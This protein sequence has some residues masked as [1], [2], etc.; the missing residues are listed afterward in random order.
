MRDTL[1]DEILSGRLPA[2][3]RLDEN[4]L[5]ARFG[6]SRTPIREALLQLAASG[7]VD[8][9]PRRSAVVIR[10]GPRRLVEMFE[11]MAELEA[12]CAR[13]AA[14]RA[15]DDDLNAIRGA[16]DACAAAAETSDCDVYYYENE[17]FHEAVV[18]AARNAFLAEQTQ[19]LRKRLKP[20]RRLQLRVPGRIEES[21]GE[22]Q[23][24]A[25]A[26]AAHDVEGAAQGMR[27]HIVVQGERFSD[28]MALLEPMATASE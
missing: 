1:E 19:A 18:A 17:L 10:I 16:L 27:G 9:R 24:V 15:N 12:M 5:A 6:L 11:V 21:L 2:G 28:L 22:H 25:T 3:T 23:R 8:L 26:I 14:R 4:G 7:L 13:L 20:Y